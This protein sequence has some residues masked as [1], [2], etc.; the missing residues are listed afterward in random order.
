MTWPPTPTHLIY[1]TPARRPGRYF[2]GVV[3]NSKGEPVTIKKAICM[4][5]EDAGTAWKQ[6]DYRTGE[7]QSQ[8][9]TGGPE[10]TRGVLPAALGTAT[11]CAC[12]TVPSGPALKR[13]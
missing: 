6:V 10:N 7:L 1:P 9:A 3:N 5:E 2:D 8:R 12:S 11:L 4:H 13:V